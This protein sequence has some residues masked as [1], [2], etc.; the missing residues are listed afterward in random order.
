[1]NDGSSGVGRGGIN[2]SGTASGSGTSNAPAA[3][4]AAAS[5]AA[6]AAAPAAPLPG[7]VPNQYPNTST[8]PATDGSYVNRPVH[9]QT[10]AGHEGHVSGGFHTDGRS[11]KVVGRMFADHLLFLRCNNLTPCKTYFD[12]HM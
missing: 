3:A 1:M 9:M 5:A 6:P 12:G 2:T 10:V 4:P 8:L 7:R 11:N